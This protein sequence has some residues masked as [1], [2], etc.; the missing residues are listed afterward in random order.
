MPF[1]MHTQGTKWVWTCW[2]IKKWEWIV[3]HVS[4]KLTQK[5]H[6][7]RQTNHQMYMHTEEILHIKIQN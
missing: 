4:V 3:S 5:M 7:G 6:K 2:N 1:K